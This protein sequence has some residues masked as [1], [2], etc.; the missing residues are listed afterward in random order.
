M[1]FLSQKL[2]QTLMDSGL[3]TGLTLLWPPRATP[4]DDSP[5]RVLVH[6]PTP[7]EQCH[8]RETVLHLS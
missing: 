5:Q 6:A 8:G 1:T 4:G 3:H 2:L 7:T